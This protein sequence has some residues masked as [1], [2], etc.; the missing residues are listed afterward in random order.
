MG[1]VGQPPKSALSEFERAADQAKVDLTRR[2][3]HILAREYGS[4]GVDDIDVGPVR[5]RL[6]LAGAV[7]EREGDSRGG[8]STAGQ[9]PDL[10]SVVAF[11]G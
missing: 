5:L 8:R 7:H 1:N 6:M 4:P 10:R 3:W 2:L 9:L 11:V